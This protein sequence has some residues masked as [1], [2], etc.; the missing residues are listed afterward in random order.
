M[1]SR[2]NRLKEDYVN[3]K[4]LMLKFSGEGL[5]GV[6][7]D[8]WAELDKHSRSMPLS[9]FRDRPFQHYDTITEMIGDR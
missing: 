7:D 1:E 2:W 9:R 5:V 6:S 4:W 3:Y 8:A